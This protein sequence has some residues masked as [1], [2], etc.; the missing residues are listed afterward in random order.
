MDSKKKNKKYNLYILQKFCIYYKKNSIYTLLQSTYIKEKF[1]NEVN[2]YHFIHTSPIKES[3]WEEINMNIVKNY[4]SITDIANGN[5]MSGKDVKFNK[6]NISNKT[7]KLENNKLNISSYRLTSV[8][9]NKEIGDKETILN[10]IEK[11]DKNFDYY[12]LLIRDEYKKNIIYYWCIIPK[13]YILFNIKKQSFKEK[14]GKKGKHKDKIVGWQGE[15]F[16]IKFSM[17]SQ[18]WF[19]FEFKDIKK[20]I[21]C[22]VDIKLG[23]TISYSDIFKMFNA[24]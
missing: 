10:E 3:I 7:C 2:G 23:K 15:Y 21:I 18:L 4:C 19:H 11:R 12:S 1:I 16:D 8:C 24:N 14:M 13:K 20:F 22:S 5:H 6:W 9:N 17:S